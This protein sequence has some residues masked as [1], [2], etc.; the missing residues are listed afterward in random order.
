MHLSSTARQLRF[1]LSANQYVIMLLLIAGFNTRRCRSQP[2]YKVH[3]HR[4]ASED[5]RISVLQTLAMFRGWWW[6]GC[7]KTI[8][9][10]SANKVPPCQ[11]PVVSKRA[12]GLLRILR[13]QCI[14][15]DM[16]D[17]SKAVSVGGVEAKRKES[18]DNGD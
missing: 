5:A 18:V 17:N 1:F 14:M 16:S 10:L 15:S 3:L 12:L 2:L 7:T 6:A 11:P 13:I 4:Q 9:L 8:R